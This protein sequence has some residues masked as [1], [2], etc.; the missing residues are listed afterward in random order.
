MKLFDDDL[1]NIVKKFSSSSDFEL[2]NYWYLVFDEKHENYRNYLETLF[3][4]FDEKIQNKFKVLLSKDCKGFY[5]TINEII[6]GSCLVNLG[7][8]VEYEPEIGGKTP[9]W[10]IETP[11]KQ[12]IIID[13]FTSNTPTLMQSQFEVVSKLTENIRKLPSYAVLWGEIIDAYT[14]LRNIEQI[15]QD[16]SRWLETAPKLNECFSSN[17][18]SLF[19]RNYRNKPLTFLSIRINEKKRN[20]FRD[21]PD[22]IIEKANRYEKISAD[23]KIPFVVAIAFDRMIVDEET[24]EQFICEFPTSYSEERFYFDNNGK[25]VSEGVF[26][27]D[28]QG[29]MFKLEDRYDEGVFRKD[30]LSGVLTFWF[31]SREFIGTKLFRNPKATYVLQEELGFQE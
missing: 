8:S 25:K 18:I 29:G 3:S 20:D 17:G 26:V 9:D 31:H 24:I 5:E 10:I 27:P 15:T 22:K 12:K 23:A 19:V 30:S 4:V 7:C 16:I 6:I 14:A 11:S 1:K 13:V 28:G 21:L 2:L